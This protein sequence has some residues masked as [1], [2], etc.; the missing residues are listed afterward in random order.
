MIKI[1]NQKNIGRN[2][3]NKKYN[4]VLLLL[5]IVYLFGYFS[6]SKTLIP[7]MCVIE[8]FLIEHIFKIRNRMM[9]IGEILIIVA[10]MI[11]FIDSILS[12]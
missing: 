9:Q 5:F 10:S 4:I 11:L 1:T 12:L 3:L 6:I 7:I 2:I 8:V